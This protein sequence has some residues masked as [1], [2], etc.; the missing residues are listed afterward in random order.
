MVGMRRRSAERAMKPPSR[1]RETIT[2][3]GLSLSSGRQAI[4]GTMRPCQKRA[5]SPS[6]R[7]RAARASPSFS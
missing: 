1:D 6:G 2:A 5:I 7:S 4:P 3:R